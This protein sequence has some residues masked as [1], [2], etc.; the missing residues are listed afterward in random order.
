MMPRQLVPTQREPLLGSD[1]TRVDTRLAA[2]STFTAVGEGECERRKKRRAPRSRRCG[3]RWIDAPQRK[4]KGSGD[5]TERR[6]QRPKTASAAAEVGIGETRRGTKKWS[7]GKGPIV[8]RCGR[9]RMDASQRAKKSSS[10]CRPTTASAA[11]EVGIGETR[12]GTKEWSL[13]EGFLARSCCR[14]AGGCAEY[15]VKCAAQSAHKGAEGNKSIDISCSAEM[16][17]SMGCIDCQPRRCILG[18]LGANGAAAAADFERGSRR[19]T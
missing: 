14:E 19:L 4:K 12:R 18:I 9:G 6:Y 17:K 5:L 15:F 1:V 11:A 2:P 3:R 13:G 10:V 7:P 8:R 16:T